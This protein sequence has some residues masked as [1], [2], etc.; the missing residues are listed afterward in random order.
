MKS[1]TKL[2]LVAISIFAIACSK[3]STDENLVAPV[4]DNTL[5]LTKTERTVANPIRNLTYYWWCTKLDSGDKFAFHTDATGMMFYDIDTNTF[6]DKTSSPEF[7]GGGSLESRLLSDGGGG[8]FYISNSFNKYNE[9]TN[10]WSSFPSGSAIFPSNIHTNFG[11]A[12]AVTLSS[13]GRLYYVGGLGLG[14]TVKYFNWTNNSWNY[15]AGYPIPIGSSPKLTTDKV[16]KI[17]AL[18]GS[19][20]IDGSPINKLCV[21]DVTKNTWTELAEAPKFPAYEYSRNTIVVFKNHIIYLGLDKKLYVYDIQTN[22]W[23]TTAFETD[24]YN[25][26]DTHLELSTDGSKIYLIYKK[27]NSAIGIQEY[28]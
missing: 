6:A 12:G 10:T 9:I 8:L 7:V 2:A 13:K 17:Y 22:K 26:A 19:S 23:Q 16:D 25:A 4:I 18:G 3:S 1:I 11:R 5:I 28:K 21:F 14:T 15:V 20:S 27:S 24:I